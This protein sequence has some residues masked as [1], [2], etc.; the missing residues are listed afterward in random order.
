MGVLQPRG[1]AD[2]AVEALGIEPGGQLR[3]QDLHDY[4]APQCLVL[5]DEDATHPTAPEFPL[6]HIGITKRDMKGLDELGPASR[7]LDICHY[8][9]ALREEATGAGVSPKQ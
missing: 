2:L 3:R 5:G 6:D 1:Q 7:G 9:P 4:P 8:G